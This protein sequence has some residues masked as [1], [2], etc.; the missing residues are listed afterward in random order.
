M[1]QKRDKSRSKSWTVSMAPTGYFF[2]S[3]FMPKST[4][5]RW[6]QC[7]MSH[8]RFDSSFRLDFDGKKSFSD[9]LE[10]N[11]G[12]SSRQDKLNQN[13]WN[14]DDF[15]LDEGKSFFFANVV[16]RLHRHRHRFFSASLTLISWSTSIK[17][18]LNSQDAEIIFFLFLL[19]F[20]VFFFRVFLT[21]KTSQ[22][23]SR[24]HWARRLRLQKMLSVEKIM[25]YL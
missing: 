1:E 18:F 6:M 5:A 14:V 19:H 23:V 10:R 4:F 20:S 25:F 3:S 24:L 22:R 2:T 9:I 15:F 13:I 17:H 16:A 21:K 8:T 12:V 7:I 11:R